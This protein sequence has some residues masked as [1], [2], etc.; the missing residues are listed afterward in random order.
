MK[1]RFIVTRLIPTTTRWRFRLLFSSILMLAYPLSVTG[2]EIGGKPEKAEV[3]VAYVSPSALFC[4]LYAAAEADL[5]AK[6]GLKVKP[7]IMGVGTAQKALLSDEIDFLVNG[8]LLILPR[9]GGARVKYI[10][11]YVK[12]YIFQI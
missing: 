6:Y 1:A 8:P 2:A 9:L 4:P 10:G 5:F 11:A 7:Q 3:T 12:R